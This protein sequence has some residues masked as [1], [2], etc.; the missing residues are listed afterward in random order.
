MTTTEALGL[1][2]Q[3]SMDLCFSYQ[4]RPKEP[5]GN[6]SGSTASDKPED[7]N[8]NRPSEARWWKGSKAPKGEDP[9]GKRYV[10]PATA[11]PVPPKRK[12]ERY[13]YAYDD[14]D[15]FSI[16]AANNEESVPEQEADD[17]HINQAK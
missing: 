6:R 5:S 7:S 12:Y 10:G 16:H 1:T 4:E 8:G 3:N 13:N 15:R 9:K 17:M 14:L 2:T 11:G